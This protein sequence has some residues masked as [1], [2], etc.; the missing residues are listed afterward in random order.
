MAE[1]RDAFEHRMPAPLQSD[2]EWALLWD[3]TERAVVEAEDYSTYA[4]AL[5]RA[6][7]AVRDAHATL[8]P[9]ALSSMLQALRATAPVF[10]AGIPIS[11][12]G[13]CL[14]PT[15]D[16]RLVVSRVGERTPNPYGLAPGDEIV[17]YD[18]QPWREWSAAL[19]ASSLPLMPPPAGA[20]SARAYFLATAAMMN[21]RW[22]D[23]VQIRPAGGGN[24]HSEPVRKGQSATLF[25]CARAR[26]PEGL[27]RVAGGALSSDPG[28]QLEYGV[29][30]ADSV[31][32]LLVRSLAPPGATSIHH[33]AAS[34]WATAFAEAVR[35]LAGTR[36][37]II[38]LRVNHGGLS[39][40]LTHA[41][42]VQLVEGP[43]PGLHVLSKAVRDPVG[44]GPHELIDLGTA[45]PEGCA[46]SP[47]PD[48]FKRLCRSIRRIEGGLRDYPPLRADQPDRAYPFPVEVLTGPSC[49]SSCDMLVHVLAALPGV[50]VAG[51]EPAGSLSGVYWPA[52]EVAVTDE[53]RILMSVPT[54]VF[55]LGAGAAGLANASRNESVVDVQDW[56]TAEDLAQGRDGMVHR[57]RTRIREARYARGSP[58]SSSAPA[59][60]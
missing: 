40:E 29:F 7:D 2:E 48:W 20:P 59:A 4:A 42:L 32:Y 17:G 13:A 15:L 28:A 56:H 22:F 36:G 58:R 37:L 23:S 18:G 45:W 21:A 25:P 49:V 43:E 39:P 9:G 50:T 47:G 53:E 11:N 19:E 38:D 55:S 34:S 57:A 8:R 3:E 31:G 24:A 33:R 51:R 5:T 35:A 54:L 10:Y 1:V 12:I 14:E 52:E 30:E 60:R 16:G 26:I 44:V 27:T 6:Q 41:G 46:A